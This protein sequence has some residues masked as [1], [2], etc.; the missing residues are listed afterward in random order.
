MRYR[1][2]AWGMLARDLF[3]WSFKLVLSALNFLLIFMD[4]RFQDLKVLM[5]D[6]FGLLIRGLI[7]KRFLCIIF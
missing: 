1:M 6:D 2:L 4:N 7:I 5:F 3:C